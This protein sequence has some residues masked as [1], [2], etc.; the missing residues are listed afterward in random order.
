M[1]TRREETAQILTSVS[2]VSVKNCLEAAAEAKG[3]V[4]TQLGLQAG[5]SENAVLYYYLLSGSKTLVICLVAR[6]RGHTL[7][8]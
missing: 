7:D 2:H 6:K 5:L 3:R 1:T 4:P 8:G